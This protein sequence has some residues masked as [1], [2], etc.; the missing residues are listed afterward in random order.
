M[1]TTTPTC[2]PTLRRSGRKRRCWRKGIYHIVV[3]KGKN[4]TL[5]RSSLETNLCLIPVSILI[6]LLVTWWLMLSKS[7]W[8][9]FRWEEFWAVLGWVLQDGLWGHHRWPP[10]QISLQAGHCQWLWPFCWWGEFTRHQL[11]FRFIFSINSSAFYV[12]LPT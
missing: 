5:L 4:L 2:K 6:L 11:T 12:N 3:K 10:L 1:Q 8:F 9:L 7:W